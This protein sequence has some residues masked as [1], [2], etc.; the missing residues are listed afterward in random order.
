M[1]TKKVVAYGEY[2]IFRDDSGSITVLRN[3]DN[4]I[5]SLRAI[6]AE[7][8]F[9]YEENWNTRTFGNKLIDELSKDMAKE[10]TGAKVIG[11]AQSRT[12]LGMIHAFVKM[13]RLTTAQLIAQLP[14][15]EVAPHCGMPKIFYTA[16]EIQQAKTEWA[17]NACFMKN[18]EWIVLDD[19]QKVALVKMWTEEDLNLL[20]KELAKYNI[21]GTVDSEYKGNDTGFSVT[22][23]YQSVSP[24]YQ[25]VSLE[26]EIEDEE[27][28][29]K[30][31]KNW[32]NALK[33]SVKQK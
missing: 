24:Y 29:I 30:N 9:K 21:T 32:L 33:K 6:S 19:G 7:I 1:A 20:Q 2:I 12:A 14:Q 8:G 10:I 18:D 31:I 11:K 22:Y 3:Y 5:E 15:K 13:Y 25:S 23:Y 26:N 17:A 4:V 28:T 27:E 16:E